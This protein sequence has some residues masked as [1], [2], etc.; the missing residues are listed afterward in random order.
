M[1]AELWLL[2][3][4]KILFKNMDLVLYFKVKSEVQLQNQATPH[5]GTE[6][7]VQTFFS[8][9][10]DVLQSPSSSLQVAQTNWKWY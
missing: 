9:L 2:L 10:I 8:H 3:N 4:L 6:S 5:A 7:R 1:A